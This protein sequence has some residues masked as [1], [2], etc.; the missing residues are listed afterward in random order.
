MSNLF[1]RKLEQRFSLSEA[2]KEALIRASADV[3][4]VGA[5]EDLIREGDA[6]D[7]VHLIQS[8]F[9]CRYKILPNG[10]RSIMAYL[11]PGDLCD[12]H[13]HILGEM[14]HS[15]AT[16]SPCEIVLIPRETIDDLVA[17]YP[18]LNRALLWAGLVDGAIL[19]E[20]LVTMGRRSADKHI[21]HLFC[22]LLMR[23]EAVGLVTDNS[24]SL[25]ITQEELADTAGLTSVHVN[26]VLRDLRALDLIV[27]KSRTLSIPDI[28]RLKAFQSSTRTICTCIRYAQTPFLEKVHLTH[29]PHDAMIVVDGQRKLTH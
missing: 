7:H 12:L 6:P 26:R 19:R 27:L 2:D 29:K 17:N 22:E 24:Y 16:L 13:V 21:A 15:I 8:G 3:K 25:P 23:L 5:G 1:L 20:W 14:D 28:A 10:G 11:V 9:A 18:T 4:W